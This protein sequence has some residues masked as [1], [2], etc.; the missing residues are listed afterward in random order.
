V[1]ALKTVV[2][3]GGTGTRAALTNYTVAGKS[4]TAQ[5][6]GPGGYQAGK[7]ISSFIGFFPADRPE[8]CISIVIDEPDPTTGYY[9]G[10]VAAPVFR[11]VATSVAGYLQIPPDVP[12]PVQ[13]MAA[14]TSDGHNTRTQ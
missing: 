13:E 5:K 8:V 14:R 6:P 11:E 9:G 10:S 3:P 7:Y 4:G 1:Q 2:E 12:P